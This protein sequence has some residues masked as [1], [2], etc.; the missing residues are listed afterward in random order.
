MDKFFIKSSVIE[1]PRI[2]EVNIIRYADRLEE[3]HQRNLEQEYFDFREEIIDS[4]FL[5]FVDQA[6]G[7]NHI[8]YKSRVRLDKQFKENYGQGYEL[9]TKMY[10]YEI[11]RGLGA[12]SGGIK[13]P[14]VPIRKGYLGARKPKY[15][16]F[17]NEHD[18]ENIEKEDDQTEDAQIRKKPSAEELQA[19][20]RK[21]LEEDDLYVSEHKLMKFTES[22]EE[23]KESLRKTPKATQEGVKSEAETPSSLLSFITSTIRK[24]DD[25]QIKGIKRSEEDYM[26]VNEKRKSIGRLHKENMLLEEEIFQLRKIK[27]DLS[28][29]RDLSQ[30]D[31]A[32]F[33]ST[34]QIFT[35]ILLIFPQI[36]FS[37]G[38]E[39]LVLN[40]VS[41]FFESTDGL[42]LDEFWL[43]HIVELNS[44]CALTSY[45]DLN[46]SIHNAFDSSDVGLSHGF[47]NYF[48]LKIG[49]PVFKKFISEGWDASSPQ[50]LVELIMCLLHPQVNRCTTKFAKHVFVNCILHHL[51]DTIIPG[52]DTKSSFM[53][54]YKYLTPWMEYINQSKNR[55]VFL[56]ALSKRLKARIGDFYLRKEL[57]LWDLKELLQNFAPILR[58]LDRIFMCVTLLI[59]GLIYSI[60]RDLDRQAD[61]TD[62]KLQLVNWL[63]HLMPKSIVEN[64]VRD[65]LDRYAKVGV[66]QRIGQCQ[67]SMEI[68]NLLSN[69][70][71]AKKL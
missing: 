69:S 49:F 11:G 6:A 51:T 48:F 42:A 19:K 8:D 67:R 34:V 21:I 71:Y 31:I 47:F 40:Y 17:E 53:A 43:V 38:L 22:V 56:E 54:S 9:T 15:A 59:P 35:E 23:F 10:G 50:K 66:E 41:N 1:A 36:F 29:I 28:A 64:L 3:T 55:P 30:N 13:E 33:S 16:D 32:Q 61:L 27:R 52:F 26:E 24:F 45:L 5:D 60:E 62:D 20:L 65:I 70:D 25:K 44:V 68:K 18:T 14:I 46:H 37:F 2:T 57:S 12:K 58:P 63:F 39:K 7:K 4:E